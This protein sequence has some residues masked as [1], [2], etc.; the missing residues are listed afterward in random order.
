MKQ[1]L[2]STWRVGWGACVL[3]LHLCTTTAS[4]GAIL[5]GP[6][7]NAANGHIYYLLSPTN[8]PSA[9]S[10]AVSLGGHL[11]TI[12]DAEE[13]TWVFNRFVTNGGVLRS[14]WLGLNDAAQEGTWVW[15][16]GEA[17]AYRNWAPG[18][19][20]NGGGYF[21]DEDQAVM[22]G[23]ALSYPDSWNDAPGDQSHAAVVE[24]IAM[25]SNARVYDVAAD[26]STNSNPNGVWS[27]GYS[28]TL[29]GPVT[30][31]NERGNLAGLDYWRTDIWL[32]VPGVYFNP[33]HSTVTNNTL[34]LGPRQLSFHP[35][36]NGE[37]CLIRFTAPTNGQYQVSGVFTGVDTDGTTTDVHILVNGVIFD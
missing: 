27:Y 33:G 11:V 14:L 31:H 9:E 25:T 2:L 7:T 26:F 6:I 34:V 24:L 3:V 15:V 21:P 1:G 8:W 4:T 5:A 30:L 32:G 37:F 19:P 28:T 20:N 36:P 16:G 13:N 23:P 18:E 12:N 22:R 17:A 10:Q 29:A 35:G